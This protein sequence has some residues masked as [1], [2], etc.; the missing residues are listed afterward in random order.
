MSTPNDR[1]VT[2]SD[3][4]AAI[5]K[6]VEKVIEHIHGVGAQLHGQIQALDT[7]LGAKKGLAGYQPAP[8]RSANR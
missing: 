5:D 8:P 6:A 1:P 4:E 3:L 7:R 2:K